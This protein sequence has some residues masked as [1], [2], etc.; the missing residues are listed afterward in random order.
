MGANTLLYVK[1][2]RGALTMRIDKDDHQQMAKYANKMF[3]AEQVEILEED[4]EEKFDAHNKKLPGELISRKEDLLDAGANCNRY[5]PCPICYKCRVKGSH[6]YA[7]CDDC[8]IPLCVHEPKVID[9]WIKRDNF[10][11]KIPKGVADYLEE[12]SHKG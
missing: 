12:V 5:E 7:K 1:V 2:E 9:R 10:A 6:I 4:F 8:V 11:Q 3:G